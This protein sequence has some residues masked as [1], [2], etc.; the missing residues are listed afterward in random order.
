MQIVLLLPTHRGGQRTLGRGGDEPAGGIVNS[1]HSSKEEYLCK[2]LLQILLIV[3]TGTFQSSWHW[4]VS[5]ELM[6]PFAFFSVLRGSIHH[7]QIPSQELVLRKTGR[8]AKVRD[9]KKQCQLE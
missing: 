6:L 8:Q 4:L 3:D 1:L 5:R 7:K 2:V 9:K